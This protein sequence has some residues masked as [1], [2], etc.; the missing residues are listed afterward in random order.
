M[1]NNIMRNICFF[2][3]VTFWGGGEKL[4]LEYAVEFQKKNY[5]II[6]AA[7][8]D[9]PLYKKAQI[10]NFKIFQV[11]VHNLSFLN[12]YKI[13]KLILFLKK[14]Q[15]DTLILSS[16]QDLKLG[17]IAAKLSGVKKIVY[18]RGL[19][20]PIKRNVI[21]L[22][23]FKHIL[24]H[25]VANSEETKRRIRQN[26][27]KH[28]SPDKIKVIYH[29]IEVIGQNEDEKLPEIISSGRGVI[30]GSAGRL[31]HQKGQQYLIEVAQKIKA[32][33]VL[34]TLFIAGTGETM[35]ELE[36][37]IRKYDLQKEVIL[38]GFVENMSSFMNSIDI[39][40]Q[41]SISEGFGFVLVEAMIKSKPVI[42]FDISSSPEIVLNNETGLLVDFPNLNM[43]AEKTQLLVNNKALRSQLGKKAKENVLE[44]FSLDERIDELEKY[45]QGQ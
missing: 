45:L 42:A 32:S 43:F 18:L 26:L 39:F 5:N 38:L 17:S 40:L 12:P 27:S 6:L 1:D 11:S 23:V 16:S 36:E 29:G 3:S 15:I 21:N 41:S 9:S 22:I 8:K 37:L 34:F 19:A 44:R 31:N 33:G 14:N 4:Y 25:I 20:V 28:I 10:L 24:T 2:D 7:A 30:L 35:S 13:L